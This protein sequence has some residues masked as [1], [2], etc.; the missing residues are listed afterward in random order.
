MA[1]TFATAL[2]LGRSD[3]ETHQIHTRTYRITEKATAVL[4]PREINDL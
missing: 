4:A 2:G 1:V 3:T